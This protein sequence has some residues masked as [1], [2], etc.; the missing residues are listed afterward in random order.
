MRQRPMLDI[1]R[2]PAPHKC[3]L[4]VVKRGPMAMSV[5]FG[6]HPWAAES[7]S[8]FQFGLEVHGVPFRLQA[9][10]L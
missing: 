7:V 4:P 3:G 8:V 10:K 9:L 5:T 1:F 6:R 2:P